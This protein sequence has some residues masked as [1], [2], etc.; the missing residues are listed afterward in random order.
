MKKPTTRQ[1]LQYKF[2]NI[3]SKGTASLLLVF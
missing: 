3:M 1:V 2:D